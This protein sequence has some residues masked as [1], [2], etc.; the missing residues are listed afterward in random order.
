MDVVQ[1]LEV[2]SDSPWSSSTTP[3]VVHPFNRPIG[4][5]VTLSACILE[6]FKLFFTPALV[7]L[8]VEQ[9]NL[10]ARQVM[11][12]DQYVKW[13]DVDV[14]EIWAYMGFMILMGINHLPALSDYWKL[15]STYRYGPI[16]DRITRDRFFEITCYLHFVDNTTLLPRGDP[17]YDKLGKVRPVIDMLSIQ[18]LRNYNPHRENSIDEA[19]IKFKGRSSMKQ[20]KRGFKVWVRADAVTG[21]VCEF[22]V[23]TG[24]TT[25]QPEL[26]LGG[27]SEKVD[28]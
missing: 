9:T 27:N 18:F 7:E 14:E 13:V 26:G 8:I 20:V 17:G 5:A 25:G 21:Y 15:D 3:V 22:E 11:S 24:K 1:V 4:L 12:D 16:A 23:Y 2:T 28:S 19:M 6:V 10:Y